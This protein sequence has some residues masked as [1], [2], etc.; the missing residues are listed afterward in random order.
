MFAC[1]VLGVDCLP[2]GRTATGTYRCWRR[3]ASF[4]AIVPASERFGGVGILACCRVFGVLFWAGAFVRAFS[5]GGADGAG[6][7]LATFRRLSTA[8]TRV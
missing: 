1:W 6:R 8:V 4:S 5:F 2:K 3:W 7:R